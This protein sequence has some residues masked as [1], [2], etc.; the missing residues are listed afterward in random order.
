MATG[1]ALILQNSLST[2]L[3][4]SI[5]AVLQAFFLGKGRCAAKELLSKGMRYKSFIM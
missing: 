1:G 2:A 5:G 3:G 4:A